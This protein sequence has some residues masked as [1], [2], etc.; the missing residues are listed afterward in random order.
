[1]DLCN[2]ID[3]FLI[4][5]VNSIKNCEEPLNS[6]HEQLKNA[7]FLS[8]QIKHEHSRRYVLRFIHIYLYFK[9]C[10]VNLFKI[11]INYV[12]YV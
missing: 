6:I 1:M 2:Y 5:A 8:Q 4:R 9:V 11:F 7:L 10:Q 3:F 12:L